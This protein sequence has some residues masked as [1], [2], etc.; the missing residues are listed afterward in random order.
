MPLLRYQ[1]PKMYYFVKITDKDKLIFLASSSLAPV[2]YVL[3]YLSDPAKSTKLSFPAF[4][5][6][7]PVPSW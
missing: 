3:L 6:Y 7:F 2:A 4:I 1:E 5:F